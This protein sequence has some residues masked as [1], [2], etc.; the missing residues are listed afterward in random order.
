MG[1]IP[2]VE[3]TKNPTASPTEAPTTSPSSSS[4][5]SANPIDSPSK[6]LHPSTNPTDGPTKAPT[7]IPTV[8][9]TTD[10]TP[11]PT[12]GPTRKEID[13]VTKEPAPIKTMAPTTSIV[14]PSCDDVFL[15]RQKGE[16]DIDLE[17]VVKVISQDKM[18]V[19]VELTQGWDQVVADLYVNNNDYYYA[20]DDKGID[21]I[22]YSYSQGNY[23]EQ[24][25][26]K[27]EVVTD[28]PIDTIEIT[29]FVTKPFALLELCLVDDL[30]NGYLTSK[31]NTT[32]P[33]CCESPPEKPTVCYKLDINCVPCVD[34]TSRPFR[35][36]QLRRSG[37]LN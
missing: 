27:T 22:F 17:R 34:D 31:D 29:C 4:Y 19:T 1:P 30:D 11:L 18:T 28:A 37:T 8:K 15:F 36:R 20:R 32:V 23:S 7:P 25:Y 24:C 13:S 9:P 6:S 5:P 10:P 16:T 33:E 14:K 35:R 26:E 12:P 2:T 3:P 21:H